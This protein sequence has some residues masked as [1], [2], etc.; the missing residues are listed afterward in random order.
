MWW[1]LCCYLLTTSSWRTT[2]HFLHMTVNLSDWV[3]RPRTGCSKLS[4]NF[5]RQLINPSSG[6][7]F[8]LTT[9]QNP[10]LFLPLPFSLF[11]FPLHPSSLPSLCP[12]FPFHFLSL[13]SPLVLSFSPFPLPL[14]FFLPFLS[15][16]SSQ[17]VWGALLAPTAGS[18]A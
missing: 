2:W 7:R 3:D 6:S 10:P 4:C 15:P 17:E 5:N 12:P 9:A 1:S 16:K 8:F 11:P 14:P 18:A 13:S